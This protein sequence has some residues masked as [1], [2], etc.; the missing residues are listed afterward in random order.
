MQTFTAAPPHRAIFGPMLSLVNWQLNLQSSDC[1]PASFTARVDRRAQWR[2]G[3][4]LRDCLHPRHYCSARGDSRRLVGDIVDTLG[5]GQ[6]PGSSEA[7]RPARAAW[8]A[9]RLLVEVA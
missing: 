8:S 4:A 5:I 2:S 7:D 1:R 6:V 9:L 3:C